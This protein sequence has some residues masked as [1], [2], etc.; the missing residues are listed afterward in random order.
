[1]K[2]NIDHEPQP[3]QSHDDFTADR[4]LE[5]LRRASHPQALYTA[6]ITKNHENVEDMSD[7]R[8]NSGICRVV[9]ADSSRARM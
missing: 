5:M 4:G 1:M 3:T 2:N 7:E 6:W 8:G 9:L